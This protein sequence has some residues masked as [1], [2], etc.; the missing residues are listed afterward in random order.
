MDVIKITRNSRYVGHY[1]TM[2]WIVSDM[3]DGTMELL[4]TNADYD[5]LHRDTLPLIPE[6]QIE[7]TIQQIISRL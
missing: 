7:D 3:C 2:K 5:V 6:N 4:V 1:G